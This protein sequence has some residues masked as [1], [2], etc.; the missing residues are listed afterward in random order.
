MNGDGLVLALDRAPPAV[1]QGR[2]PVRARG[3]LQ[4]LPCP[5]SMELR[6]TVLARHFASAE[7]CLSRPQLPALIRTQET[8]VSWN[9]YIPH[10]PT[11]GLRLL[12]DRKHQLMHAVA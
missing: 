11:E 5:V 4:Y 3:K 10:T 2:Q 1:E 12:M 7:S 9:G 8:Q 6:T